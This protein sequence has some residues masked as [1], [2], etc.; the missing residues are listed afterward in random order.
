MFFLRKLKEK[1]TKS[2]FMIMRLVGY[3]ELK[4]YYNSNI[5]DL[6]YHNFTTH[7]YPCYIIYSFV[8]PT[9]LKK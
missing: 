2:M 4:M 8:G 1:K 9:K 7:L 5:Y 3:D 6:Y